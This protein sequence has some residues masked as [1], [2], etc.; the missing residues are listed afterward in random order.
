MLRV[1]LLG[2]NPTTS[3]I[4]HHLRYTWVNRWMENAFQ[5]AQKPELGALVVVGEVAILA[6]SGGKRA[7][8]VVA[9]K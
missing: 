2:L 1:V 4:P 7:R 3:Q 8:I 9:N 5:V 6:I